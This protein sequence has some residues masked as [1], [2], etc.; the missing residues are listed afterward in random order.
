MTATSICRSGTAS[1]GSP[2][3]TLGRVAVVGGGITGLASAYRLAQMGAS[4]TLFEAA[5]ECGG[6]GGSFEHQGAS[7]EKFY[8]CMLPS[9]R[10]LLPLLEELGIRDRVYWGPS[11][12]GYLSRGRVFPLNSPAD[13][14]RFGPLTPLQRIRVG[15]T[16]VLGKLAS[17]DGLDDIS[18]S[19]WLSKTSGKPAFDTFWRPLLRAKFGEHYGEVPAMWFWTRFH[20]EKGENEEVKGYIRGGYR[21]IVNALVHAIRRS[22]G[23]IV[24]QAGVDGIDLNGLGEPMVLRGERRETFDRVIVA[25]PFVTFRDSL[26]RGNVR[27]ALPPTADDLDLQG[28]VNTV[29]V[30]TKPL[31][32]HY[33][34]AAVDADLPFQGIVEPSTLVRPEDRGGHSLLHLMNYTHRR[35]ELFHQD[36]ETIGAAM[37]QALL[38]IFPHYP[39][40]AIVARRVFRAPYVEPLLTLGYRK[41]VPPMEL[42]N[43]RVFLATTSQVYPDITAWNG[44]IGLVDRLVATVAAAAPIFSQDEQTRA[45]V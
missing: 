45:A 18:V 34:T 25:T 24:L 30:T 13:L 36:D 17:S 5:N 6:L 40:E 2:H 38:R 27:R 26:A 7:L 11:S 4:V 14:L 8:H 15:L 23:K 43:G 33:W 1:Q 31:S 37:E 22:G 41:K 20:R 28:V 44:A 10:F 32:E 29:L 16:A 12:F 9:D 19:E 42:I 3:E 39:R 35:S 21:T